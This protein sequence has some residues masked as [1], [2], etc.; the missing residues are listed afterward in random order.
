[1]RVLPLA[2]AQVVEHD[3]EVTLLAH[4]QIAVTIDR[5]RSESAFAGRVGVAPPALRHQLQNLPL[6]VVVP[7]VA[8]PVHK[9]FV[10]EHVGNGRIHLGTRDEV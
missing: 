9:P 6:A 8:A 10:S 3:G 7:A 4:A 1:M 5:E 2:R